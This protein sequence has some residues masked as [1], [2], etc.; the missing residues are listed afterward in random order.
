M[1]RSRDFPS[2]VL[3]LVATP[4]GNLNDISP[5]TIDVLNNVSFVCAED[6]RVTKTLLSYL[7]IDKELVSYHSYNEKEIVDYLIKRI[8]KE[9]SVALC[10]DAGYPLISD[11]GSI[12]VKEAI[13]ND[14]IVSVI[15]G[16]SALLNGLI[17]SSLPC[18]RFYFHGF[19]PSKSGERKQVLI[20]L[21]SCPVTMIFYESPHRIKDT[22]FDLKDVLGNRNITIAREL[23]K[24][25]EEYIYLT[26]DEIDSLDF[27][28]IRGELVLIIEGNNN[29]DESIDEK[30]L[31][32][33]IED[34]KKDFSNKEVLKILLNKYHLKK[35][36]LYDLIN[37]N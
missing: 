30:S 5:R 26:L 33:E 15:P 31:L 1:K 17:G 34:L 9:G 7:K 12:L 36:Y 35:N 27:D 13:K 2:R 21:K 37:K 25:Y 10:S 22:L 24:M 11:P 29:K 14:I 8:I 28:T 20:K 6:T 19:L 16:P 3:Y 23:T 18:D 4:I 32:L